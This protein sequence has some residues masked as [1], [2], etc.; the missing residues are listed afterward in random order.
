MLADLG[1]AFSHSFNDL[2]T[3]IDYRWHHLGC[4]NS[5]YCGIR[6]EIAFDT[7]KWFIRDVFA[8]LCFHFHTCFQH[9]R[10]LLVIRI[11]EIDVRFKWS[12]GIV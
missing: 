1:C 8:F 3:D 4:V 12:I 9:W 2:V 5:I 11:F 10:H 6:L 7:I